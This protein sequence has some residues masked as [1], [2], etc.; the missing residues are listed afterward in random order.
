[1][2]P[3]PFEVMAGL[4]IHVGLPWPIP[5]LDLRV[6]L[7]WQTPGPPRV[8][9]PL[10]AAGVEHLLTAASWKLDDASE[11][12]IPL[13]GRISLLFERGVNDHGLEGVMPIDATAGA[14]DPLTVGDYKLQANLEGLRLETLVDGI[15]QPYVPNGQPQRLYGMWQTEGDSTKRNRRLLLHV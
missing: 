1:Q 11:P 3:Q 12:V 7:E 14:V 5:D 6:K 2:A 8:T 13:D 15:W 4:M 9:A 10:Q